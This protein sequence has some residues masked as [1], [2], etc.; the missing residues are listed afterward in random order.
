MLYDVRDGAL[1]DF[2]KVR[3]A[4][5]AKC[6]KLKVTNPDAVVTA[7]F[8]FKSPDVINCNVILF[9]IGIGVAKG[10]YFPLCLGPIRSGPANQSRIH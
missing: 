6:H 3:K 8:Q 2:D 4:F 7:T 9:E 1:H 10:V 5:F